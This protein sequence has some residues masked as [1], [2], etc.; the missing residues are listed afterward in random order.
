MR[1]RLIEILEQ[2]DFDFGEHSVECA[3]EN[4]DSENYY[5]FIADALLANG[6][7]VP[8]CKVGHKV[9][10]FFETCDE[11]GKEKTRISEGVVVSFSLQEE[12]LWAY[13]RYKSGL[14][15]WHIVDKDFG[16]T[17][18]LTREEAETALKE[19]SNENAE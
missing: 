5:R 4:V 2:A 16:K 7:I 19:R 10:Y 8:P 18:F 3:V 9:F 17:V 6:V 15:Y 12:G 13:V 1:D 11:Q 14:T